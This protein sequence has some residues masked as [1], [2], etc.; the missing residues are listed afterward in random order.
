MQAAQACA[1]KGVATI[2]GGIG[3]DQTPAVRQWAEQNHQLYFHNSA[4]QKG[5]DGLH[6]SFSFG[7]PVEQFGHW[8]AQIIHDAYPGKKVAI[9]WRQSPNWQPAR[10]TFLEDA[11]KFGNQ[12]V[13]DQP[14]QLNQGNYTQELLQAR[15]AGAE[16][17]FAL[18]NS[19]SSIEM[20]KQAQAQNWYP[21]WALVGANITL[22]TLGQTALDQPIVSTS[23]LDYYTPG[24]Y[25]GGYA[26][27]A[28]YI[29]EFEALYAKDDPNADLSGDGGDILYS[30]W[31]FNR[32]MADILARCGPDCTRNKLAGILLAGYHTTVQPL[33]NYDFDTGDHHWGY[34]SSQYVRVFKDPAGNPP[35][36][37]SSA[38]RRTSE[39]ADDRRRADR[40]QHL[41]AHRP[42]IGA[43]LQDH[44]GAE[45]RPG[46][47]RHPV[48]LRDLVDL[49]EAWPAM[50]GG[51]P[52]RHRDRVADRPALRA[53]RRAADDDRPASH[54][55]RGHDRPV[56]DHARSRG[57]VVRGDHLHVARAHRGRRDLH[58]GGSGQ[59]GSAA[60]P[61]SSSRPLPRGWR[62]SSATPI[63]VSP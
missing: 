58:R 18:E 11:K 22:N 61:R 10:T 1:D 31:E 26:P 42:R 48:H 59:P 60:C 4:V 37:S 51:C 54:R 56:H 49:R 9:L 21:D 62:P 35:G 44:A 14:V 24:Y 16:V 39:H 8:F 5:S 40:G 27:V 30:N 28:K 52:R 7:A 17:V 29:K 3:W 57:R 23:L 47:G 2:L 19:L 55:G 20:V 12:V 38:A 34:H 15:S 25:G 43:G 63:S 33:C 45:L 32:L 50:V 6:Y 41:R 36:R 46:G 13:Y 53:R